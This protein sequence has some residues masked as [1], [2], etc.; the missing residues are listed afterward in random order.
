[1]RS[2]IAAVVVALFACSD[3]ASAMSWKPQT[4]REFLKRTAQA[5]LFSAASFFVPHWIGKSRLAHASPWGY[6]FRG[7]EAAF[8]KLRTDPKRIRETVPEIFKPT[9]QGIMLAW[10][11]SEKKVRPMQHLYNKAALA[12]PVRYEG[13]TGF[14]RRGVRVEGIFFEQY[15]LNSSVSYQKQVYGYPVE[16]AKIAWSADRNS[17]NSAV[18]KDGTQIARVALSLSGA[19]GRLQPSQDILHLHLPG[20]STPKPSKTRVREEERERIAA[21]VVDANL[22]GVRDY[23]VV[24][25]VYKKYDRFVA[26]RSEPID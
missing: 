16:H 13:P 2:I 10:F 11:V 4:R 15:Y 5:G 6:V 23:E 22:F 8:I 21:E 9:D 25:A 17:V 26:P 24:E 18:T 20:G 12:V 19:N 1:M 14:G 7:S 3:V